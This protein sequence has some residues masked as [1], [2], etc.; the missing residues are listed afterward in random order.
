MASNPPTRLRNGQLP[1]QTV[2]YGNPATRTRVRPR[3]RE[4]MMSHRVTRGRG[5][6]RVRESV[7]PRAY[8]VCHARRSGRALSLS[9]LLDKESM[10]VWTPTSYPP[11]VESPSSLAWLQ[12]LAVLVAT[13]PDWRRG[14]AGA[15]EN[16][17]RAAGFRRIPQLHNVSLPTVTHE[18]APGHAIVPDALAALALPPPARQRGRGG[19]SRR[20][21]W[22][23]R[24]RRWRQVVGATGGVAGGAVAGEVRWLESREGPTEERLSRISCQRATERGGPL[25]CGGA[26]GLRSRLCGARWLGN[27]GDQPAGAVRAAVFVGAGDL[28]PGWPAVPPL[29]EPSGDAYLA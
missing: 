10:Y 9:L 6:I 2:T 1:V 20:L 19:P 25:E 14:S 7:P 17:W 24:D 23:C 8:L 12:I 29:P 11:C 27:G 13:R 15:A 21:L 22:G 28:W 18:N 16:L 5:A 4:R 3:S 26:V